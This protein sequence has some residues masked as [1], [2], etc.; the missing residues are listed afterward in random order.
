MPNEGK[1]ET[2]FEEAQRIVSGAR[3]KDYGPP[4]RC[5]GMIAQQWSLF[6]RQ[7]N[8]VG[9]YLTAEDVSWMMVQLKMIRQ[10]NSKKR[11][12]LVDAIGYIGLID[13]GEENGTDKSV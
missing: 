6:L 1:K 3:Q 10:M 4:E 9:I 2:I 13:I 5:N 12:N 8:N 11:D 7:K